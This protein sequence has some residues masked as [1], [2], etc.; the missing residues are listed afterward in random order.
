SEVVAPD[1]LLADQTFVRAVE[2]AGG[3]VTPIPALYFNAATGSRDLKT[4]LGVADLSA[5]GAFSTAELAAI[6]AV[7]KYVDLTQMGRKPLINAPRKA[8]SAH[9]FIDA[10]SR[11]SLELV[12]AA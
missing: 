3:K 1:G 12:R 4:C 8:G 2:Y 9:L 10:A 5:F 7:L 11:A 6:G